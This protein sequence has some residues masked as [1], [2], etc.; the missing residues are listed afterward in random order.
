M[1]EE[2]FKASGK[3]GTYKQYVKDNQAGIA[4]F[5]AFAPMWSE[6]I[7]KKFSNKDGSINVEAI[8][9]TS[10]ELLKIISYRIPTEDKYSMAPTK[11]VGFMPREAGDAIMLPYELTEI[12]DSDF[13]VDKRYV[14]RKDIPIKRRKASEIEQMLFDKLSESYSKAHDG[15]KA[16]KYIGE[17]VKMFMNNPEKMKY[18]DS[19]M[20]VLYKEYQ[21]IAYYTEAPTSGR[22]YRDNKIIDMTWAVLTNEMT[23]DK[24]LNPGGFDNYK[25]VAYQ[26]AAFREGNVSWD[27]LQQMSIDELKELSSIDKDLS[28]ADTQV[29]F[30]RQNA[31]GS[32]LIGVFAVNKV[33]HATLESNDILLAV[34]EICGEEPFTIAGMKFGGRMYL[35][36]KYDIN[37]N[38]IGKCSISNGSECYN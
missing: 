22:T 21:R 7:F 5:E 13:D 11:I 10:P 19:L 2:E 3:Q 8:E 23:A 6:D 37:G 36:P 20:E 31:A 34:D 35:D 16:N 33:A 1:T 28:W 25:K 24:I 15:K 9:A 14:M 18:T 29:H 4:Y 27:Q 12:D 17:Q 38:L 32:N 30:Y 26:I